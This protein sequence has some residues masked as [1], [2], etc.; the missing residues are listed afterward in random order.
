[1]PRIMAL[2]VGEKT[3]GV[4][5]TDETGRQ[6]FP[7]ETI[8]R[9]EGYRRDM[10]ALRRLVAERDVNCIVVGLPRLPDGTDGIQASKVESFIDRLRN[11][12][13]I[14]IERQ[15][16]AYTTAGAEALLDELERPRNQHKRTIDSVA[17]CIILRDYLGRT[18]PPD[19]R[20]E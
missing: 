5:F 3:I 10:A 4:A 15:D 14:P 1:V 8:I 6:A 20:D 16:E 7:G 13:R 17:A 12:V 19:K 11:S 9:Q 2:D 18:L